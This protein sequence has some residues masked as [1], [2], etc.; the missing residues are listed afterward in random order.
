[1]SPG[2]I[3]SLLSKTPPATLYHYTSCAGLIGIVESKCLWASGLQHLNDIGELKH[4][5]SIVRKLLNLHL[6]AERGPWNDLYRILLDDDLAWLGDFTIFI[7]S[8]SEAKD[9]LSQW[10]AYCSNEGGFS[11]GFD[12]GIIK[13]QAVFQHFA[14]RKCE[15]DLKRQEAICDELISVGCNQAQKKTTEGEKR[16]ALLEHFVM[17]FILIAPALKNPCFE[18]EQEWR[19]I[20]GVFDDEHPSI[21]F[22]P[23]KHT[24]IPY[25]EFALTDGKNPLELQEIIVGPNPDTLGAKNSVKYL[26]DKRQVKCKSIQE[27]S[28]TYKNW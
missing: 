18:E 13:R 15:Y 12:T 6:R 3:E 21:R 28:G 11:L 7:G 20:G 25:F 14:L 5:L 10:R 2:P 1:M 17:P 16:M 26:L 22:R 27:Y 19:L 24:V 4:A 8:F 23:G 9:K